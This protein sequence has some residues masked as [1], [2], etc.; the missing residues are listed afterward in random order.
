MASHSA[1]LGAG[2]S[3]Y[4]FCVS[5]MDSIQ[6]MT[7]KFALYEAINKLEKNLWELQICLPTAGSGRVATQDFSKCLS[8]KK[9][10]S[11]IMQR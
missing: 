10:I 11:H 4:M 5:Y 9:E 8:S 7:N 2:K 1:V 3:L 6:Q